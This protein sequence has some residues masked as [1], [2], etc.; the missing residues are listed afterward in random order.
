MAT[1]GKTTFLKRQKE[2]ARKDKRQRKAERRQER[3]LARTATEKI[4]PQDEAFPA[5]LE[6]GHERLLSRNASHDG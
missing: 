6:R 3:K 5:E 1:R 4:P 2:M